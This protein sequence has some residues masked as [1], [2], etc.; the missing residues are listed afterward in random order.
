MTA[1]DTKLRRLMLTNALLLGSA[2]S[3]FSQSFDVVSV[4]PNRTGSN[5]TSTDSDNER[6]LATN[7]PLKAMIRS[8]YGLQTP[9]QI[10]GL[11]GWANSVSFDVQAKLDA[12]TSAKLKS[13][14]KD[15]STQI[16][17][18]MF[19]TMLAERFQLKVHKESRDLPIY[20]LVLAKGGS[21][22]KA[23]ED[24]DPNNGSMN[25]HNQ[26]LDA[27]GID[28]A[29]LCRHLSQQLHRKV[30]DGTGLTG[31]YT[32][33]LQWSPDEAAGESVGAT[34]GTQLPTLFT[35]LQE[36]LGLKLEPG[37]G[38]VET[39]VVDRVEMPSEN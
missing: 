17:E 8:A 27:K 24:T 31:T 37:K 35:A 38:P 39:V 20:T 32:F 28:V 36:Q 11:P 12:E 13:S 29:A 6:F 14:S 30:V 34:G 9:D 16:W 21:R 1:R 25:T 5:S 2:V 18:T 19:Q 10:S 7:L 3:V 22:L 15:V 33:T 4:K 23:A 26:S